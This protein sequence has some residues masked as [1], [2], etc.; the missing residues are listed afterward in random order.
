MQNTVA[1]GVQGRGRS[2]KRLSRNAAHR[3]VA[4]KW[5]A[6]PRSCKAIARLIELIRKDEIRKGETV[7]SSPP[8]KRLPCSMS[9]R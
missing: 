3:P 1:A 8:A 2:G 7:V 4:A 5:L 6:L 9:A